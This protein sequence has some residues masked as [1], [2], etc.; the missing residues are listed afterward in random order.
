MSGKM[1]S[2]V[3]PALALPFLGAAGLIPAA[4]IIGAGAVTYG[5]YAL[6]RRLQQDYQQALSEFNQRSFT[7]VEE[8]MAATEQQQASAAAASALAANTRV[9]ATEDAT[10]TFLQQRAQRLTER[11]AALPASSPELLADC[12]VLQHAIQESPTDIT[13][14]FETYQR[15]AEE[16]ATVAA[17]TP[18]LV[19]NALTDE[20]TA[21]REEINSPLLT[22]PECTDIHAQLLQ[23]L[24]M[25]EA[26]AG[27]RQLLVAN[28]GLALLRRRVRRELQVQAERHQE[29]IRQANEMRILV[30]EMLAKLQ[31]VAQQNADLEAQVRAVSLLAQVQTELAQASV[32]DLAA[33]RTLAKAVD[34]LFVACE[35][36]FL[37][38]A[39]SSYVGD[40]VT[41]VLL[42]MGYCVT[43]VS[44]EDTEESRTYVATVDNATAL[45]LRVD[46]NGRFTTEMVALTEQAA[47]A[48][49]PMQGN[50][51]S[52]VDQ[53]LAALRERQCTVREKFRSTLEVGERLRVVELPATEEQPGHTTA[54]PLY[55]RMDES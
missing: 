38:Q 32:D 45:Q 48:T 30:A 9:S 40:Q 46:G 39:T 20:L 25:L 41:D 35:Q 17:N 33:L 3:T 6:V 28:Q 7:A 29:R 55:M 47:E 52:L 10:L 21:L 24:E 44:A 12:Q 15:L 2:I 1:D 16:V 50:V 22:A 19:D 34:T 14:H 31:A 49:A 18:T 23:Q 42:S 54:T 11:V 13:T 37:Q 8:S 4:T 36:R 5:A 26:L 43:Q 27:D 51:C 53:I